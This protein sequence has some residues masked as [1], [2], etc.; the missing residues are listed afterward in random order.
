MEQFSAENPRRILILGGGF[1]GIN[2]ALNLLKLRIP[3]TKIT[4]IS[5]SHHFNYTPA[6]YKLATG[7]SPIETC[8][9]LGEIFDHTK[10]EVIIDTITGGTL[11][12]KVI[13]GTSGSRYRYDFLVLAL[14]AETTY[15]GIPGIAENSFSLKS[16]ETALALKRHLHSLFKEGTNLTKGEMISKFQFVIVGGGPAGVEL[17]S[18]I[19]HYT[20][21]LATHH[22]IPVH[23]V[24]ATIL[25]AVPRL[26]PTFPEEVSRRVT[27]KLDQLGI[28]IILNRP[29]TSEDTTGVYLKD[30]K[31]NSKTIIWT[32][33]VRASHIYGNITGLTLDK[34]GRI[35]V[36]EHMRASNFDTV[37]AIGDS[38]ST[39]HAGTAQT[40]NY[41]GA[42]VPKII[43]SLIENTGLLPY[44]PKITPYVIPLGKDWGIFSYKN[45][46]LSGRIFYWLRELIDF[47]FF[48]SILPFWKAYEVW[49]EGGSI[50][51][52][53]P[54]CEKAQEGCK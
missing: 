52:S 51:E 17:A 54:T 32:A 44:T 16:V 20:R 34:G 30:I 47:K 45:I 37:F 35:T 3:N 48:L 41:D 27:K 39:P 8:I 23:L 24:T 10:I 26:L 31:L 53:C 28:N 6:L 36:D 19:R 4:L 5:D 25:Q 12:E 11:A 18:V 42:Y 22:N 49:R 7:A 13:L 46:V 14:G 9:P 50:T 43:K 15:Y 40:A 38:A 29:V 21:Q 1:G 2:T 33:G